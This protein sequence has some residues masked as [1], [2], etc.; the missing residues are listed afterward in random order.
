MIGHWVELTLMLD[1]I[2][3]SLVGFLQEPK[4][5]VILSQCN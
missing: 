3:V 1:P 4:V 2:V 5:K